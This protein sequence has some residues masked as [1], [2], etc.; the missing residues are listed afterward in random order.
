MV[1]HSETMIGRTGFIH[2]FIYLFN[3]ESL[4]VDYVLGVGNTEM[5]KTDMVPTFLE[6]T[7]W[8]H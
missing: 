8:L 3:S 2:E 6:L 7:Y 1:I 5:H 4:S